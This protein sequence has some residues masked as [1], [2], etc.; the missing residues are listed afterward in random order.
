MQYYNLKLQ[1]V[2]Q[3]YAVM[4]KPFAFCFAIRCCTWLYCPQEENVPTSCCPAFLHLKGVYLWS[5]ET[6]FHD[7]FSHLRSGNYKI[8]AEVLA[9]QGW[10]FGEPGP[11]INSKHAS[12]SPNRA[13]PRS[14][15]SGRADNH[16]TSRILLKGWT[17]CLLSLLVGFFY[18]LFWNL[19]FGWTEV[20]LRF[21]P[22]WR[23][24][25]ISKCLAV[26]ARLL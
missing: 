26:V 8:P 22:K 12:S 14:S 13:W 16:Q 23:T 15:A 4:K 17:A 1:K 11:E 2:M 21:F 24:K 20:S 6:A 25:I 10:S 5:T 9:L 19:T 18:K 3:S 7:R